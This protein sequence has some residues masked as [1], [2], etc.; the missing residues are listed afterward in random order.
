MPEYSEILEIVQDFSVPDSAP[1]TLSTDAT[2]TLVGSGCS[3]GFCPGLSLS[4][5]GEA[6]VSSA[7]CHHCRAFR[8]RER[9]GI[10]FLKRQC[11]WLEFTQVRHRSRQLHPGAFLSIKAS[12]AGV[13]F[14]MSVDADVNLFD[15]PSEVP[16]SRWTALVAIAVLLTVGV[17][18]RQAQSSGLQQRLG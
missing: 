7:R 2:A 5:L 10:V 11:Q 8:K 16:E 6:I 12:N 4:I 15:P 14:Q 1:F 13:W 9:A 17:L 18:F 3:H